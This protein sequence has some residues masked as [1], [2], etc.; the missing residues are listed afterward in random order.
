VTAR[1]LK[2]QLREGKKRGRVSLGH[3]S[4]SIR[5]MDGLPGTAGEL[6]MTVML[7]IGMGASSSA[8]PVIFAKSHVRLPFLAE[9][10]LSHA[11]K[12]KRILTCV[13]C[14]GGDGGVFRL[15]AVVVSLAQL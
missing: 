6:R 3:T 8:A 10:C 1:P 15:V 4:N 12:V 14:D 13:V 7:L 5:S 9:D 2:N 11:K